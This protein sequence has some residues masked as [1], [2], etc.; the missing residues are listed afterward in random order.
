MA[1]MSNAEREFRAAYP[2]AR[3]ERH[4]TRWSGVYNYQ[5][6]A[7]DYLCAESYAP[8]LAFAQALEWARTGLITPDP[9]EPSTNLANVNGYDYK[10]QAW[11]KNG[12]Y[13]RCGHPDSMVCGC[14][15]REHI[16]EPVTVE[17]LGDIH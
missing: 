16:G 1:Q 8:R 12:R 10:R 14:Y 5:V 7:G 13:Q 6:Y 4:R 17:S 9:S 11:V 2:N 3:I 15:G